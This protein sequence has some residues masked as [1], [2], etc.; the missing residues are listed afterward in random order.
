[1]TRAEKEMQLREGN[2]GRRL[3]TK[4]NVRIGEIEKDTN[5]VGCGTL[6]DG[7]IKGWERVV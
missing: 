2:F 4:G 3:K 5:R 1:V 7:L 6:K